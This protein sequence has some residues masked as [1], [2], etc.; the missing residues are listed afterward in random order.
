VGHGEQA[1][2]RSQEARRFWPQTRE[3]FALQRRF[4]PLAKPLNFAVPFL[5]HKGGNGVA[6][7]LSL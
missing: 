2:R 1:R 3:Q 5:I 7:Q 6:T 4:A